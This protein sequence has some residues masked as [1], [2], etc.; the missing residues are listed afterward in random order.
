MPLKTL[1]A[2]DVAVLLAAV[3]VFA[4]LFPSNYETARDSAL[5]TTVLWTM[6]AAFVALIALVAI[7][8]IRR[9]ARDR[10][11]TCASSD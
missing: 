9:F 10:S 3:V 1:I 4:A 8:A 5:F 7:A 2:V 11:I 6:F